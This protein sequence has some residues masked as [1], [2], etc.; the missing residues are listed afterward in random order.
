[1]RGQDA[2]RG[3][4]SSRR[5]RLLALAAGTRMTDVVGGWCA[6]RQAATA[7]RYRLPPRCRRWYVRR[8]HPFLCIWTEIYFCCTDSC[9]EIL[10][11]ETPGQADDERWRPTKPFAVQV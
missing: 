2:A 3:R 5:T 10:R 7:S 1:M 9:H 8:F 6:A 11:M 4:V